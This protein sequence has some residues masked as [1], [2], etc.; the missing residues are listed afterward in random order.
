MDYLVLKSAH[1]SLGLISITGFVL[2]W[3]LSIRGYPPSGNRLIR[4]APH[5]I[6]TLFLASGI[7]LALTIG[8][9][10]LK[11]AWLT[12]KVCGL[13]CYIGLGVAA[14]SSRQTTKKRTV[15]FVFTV[16]V[17][18]WIVSVARL[19]SAWGFIGLLPTA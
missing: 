18:A 5:V 1:I 10:P 8:Q 16:L 9:F 15:A 11:N 2:R 14:M 6:D 13:L 19:K 3:A 4:S 17:F 7:W 12:A